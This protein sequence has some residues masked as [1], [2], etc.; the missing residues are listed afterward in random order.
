[1]NY[2]IFYFSGTGNSLKIAKDMANELGDSQIKKIKSPLENLTFG[3]NIGV[4]FPVYMFGMPNAVKT[5][6]E[7]LESVKRIFVIVSH[8]GMPGVALSQAKDIISRKNIEILGLYSVKMPDNY[9]PMFDRESEKTIDSLIQKEEKEVA[10]IAKK[11]KDGSVEMHTG[12][13]ITP[14][15]LINRIM[16]KRI[17]NTGTGFHSDEK[18]TECGICQKVCPV[19]NIYMEDGKPRWKDRCEGCMACIQW[20]PAE[21]IQYKKRTQKKKRYRA[22]GIKLSE[23]MNSR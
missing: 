17:K 16:I 22:P 12:K 21:S 23:I 15:K 20:C 7:R 9:I 11:I 13:A 3:E 2:E 1:M 18:C 10:E 6:L 14:L 8:G 19:Y 4:V 5:F